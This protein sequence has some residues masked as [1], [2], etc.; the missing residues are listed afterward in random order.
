[1][2]LMNLVTCW[3]SF[4]PISFFPIL[5]MLLGKLVKFFM[6][7]INTH[8][9]LFLGLSIFHLH[10]WPIPADSDFVLGQTRKLF[11]MYPLESYLLPFGKLFT[12]PQWHEPLWKVAICRVYPSE[13]W[14][15]CMRYLGWGPL[16]NMAIV[17]ISQKLPSTW[18]GGE[19]GDKRNDSCLDFG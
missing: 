5:M 3:K 6:C 10:S 11:L 13:R 17:K 4:C 9:L 15:T 19:C 16:W 8:N 12:T 2:N 14:H 18:G 7:Q 1:M